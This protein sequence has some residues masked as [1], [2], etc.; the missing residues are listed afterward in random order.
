MFAP[1]AHI[2]YGQLD[3]MVTGKGVA[4][5]ATKVALDQFTWTIALNSLFFYS[6]SMMATGNHAVSYKAI[7]DK[8]WPTLKVSCGDFARFSSLY[9]ITCI[10]HLFFFPLR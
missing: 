7:E 3:K 6:T 1:L 8:L 10:C 9:L 4:A 2:W 5:V